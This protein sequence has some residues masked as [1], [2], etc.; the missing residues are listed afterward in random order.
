MTDPKEVKYLLL[1]A[2]FDIKQLIRIGER[3]VTTQK[4]GYLVAWSNSCRCWRA[5]V[6][7]GSL[8]R[9]GTHTLD[10]NEIIIEAKKELV[11]AIAK[12]LD[13]LPLYKRSFEA[14]FGKVRN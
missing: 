10:A 2:N 12:H 1:K 3:N 9:A 13:E 4:G 14:K 6:G 8:M 11:T 7:E 5:R